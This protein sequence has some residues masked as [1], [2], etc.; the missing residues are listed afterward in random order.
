MKVTQIYQLMNSVTSEVLG[1][2][3]QVA[4]DLSNIVDI[5]NEIQNLNKVDH[6]VRSLVNHIGRVIFVN[7]VYSGSVPSVLRD[8]WE[9][10][11]IL[12]KITAELPEAVENKDWELEDGVSYDPNVFYKPTVS[13]KF[14][15][16][17]VTFEID[18]SFTEDQVKQSFSD[19][20]QLNAFL[21]MLHNEIDKALTIKTDALIMRTINNMMAE[22]INA[23]GVRAVNLLANY[24]AERGTS[25]TVAK[26]VTDPEFIRYASYQIGLYR[27]R[28]S[29]I[30]TMYNVG[31]KARF[32]PV[33]L[34]H[35]VMLSEFYRASSVYL[36]SDTFHDEL[37]KFPSVETV[38]Y[39]QSPGTDYG[40][41]NTSTINVTT[42]NN[43]SVK[44]S[45]ILACI[46]DRDALGVC[47]VDRKVTSHYNPKAN[48]FNEFWKFTAGYWNDLNEQMVVFYVSESSNSGGGGT[49]Y[50]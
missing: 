7:R 4:E 10:G 37:V 35:I 34:Q 33:D 13:A 49:Y 19:V 39:W 45:G 30:S 9:Y 5:G 23:G 3:A 32:T 25:L 24:N 26:C 28:L 11:S 40:F 29:K 8:S 16:E 15:N 12:E 48:F 20:T 2:T 18:M 6:Y 38:P 50:G 46:F 14:F 21:S 36:Q 47:N 27:D 43:H 44:Q 1:S 17:R 42:S 41:T 22:T 31:G